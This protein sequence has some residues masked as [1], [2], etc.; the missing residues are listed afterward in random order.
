MGGKASGKVILSDRLLAVAGMVE[1]GAVVCDVGCDHGF[2]PI[3]LVQNGISKGVI[4]MDVNR[5][6]LM[7][8]GEHIREQGLADYIETRLS[9]GLAALKAGEA[10]TVI[11]AGMGGRLMKRILED[12]KETARSMKTLIL[13]PQSELQGLREYLRC[14]GYFIAEENMILED[15]KYYPIIKACPLLAVLPASVKGQDKKD[16]DLDE[17]RE[18]RQRVEDRYGP[19]LLEKRHPVLLRFLNRE[20]DICGKILSHMDGTGSRQEQRRREIME[21]A[22]DIR[23]A[24]SFYA[25]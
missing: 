10:D 17:D 11:C 19:L 8:A 20:M 2:V 14:D 18:R 16:G 15:G 13:Q 7:A 4:A 23:L 24:L 3:Y 5:A 9:D 21:K 22:E 1:R 12:N 6:P 25:S